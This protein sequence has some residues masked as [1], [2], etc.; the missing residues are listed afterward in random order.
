[1][2]ERAV[3]QDPARAGRK[4]GQRRGDVGVRSERQIG[5]AQLRAGDRHRAARRAPPARSQ[6]RCAVTAAKS[7]RAAG[8]H[9]ALQPRVFELFRAPEQRQR[10]TATG[11]SFSAVAAYRMHVEQ[12]AVSIEDE[13]LDGERRA[14]DGHRT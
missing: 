5:V 2:R 13:R 3:G 8:A 6:A 11:Q 1:M 9:Q 4:R 10:R 7:L 14:D 12:R